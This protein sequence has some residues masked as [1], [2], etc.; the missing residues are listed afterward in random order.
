MMNRAALTTVFTLSF[1]T[2]LAPDL[3]A[4][5]QA[6]PLIAFAVLVFFK[7]YSSGS[8]MSAVESLCAPDSL[9]FVLF[10]SLLLFGT[11]IQSRLDS[12]WEFALV[13]AACLGLARLY[14]AVVPLQEVLEAFFWS[15]VVSIGI[16]VPMSI[17]GFVEAVTT[18]ARFSPFGFHPNLLAFLFGGYFCAMVWKFVTG[19]WRIRILAGTLGVVCLVIIFFASSRGAIAGLVAASA[20]V[21]GVATVRGRRHSG[22]PWRRIAIVATVILAVGYQVHSSQLF[23]T[24]YDFVDQVL[25]LSDPN[26]GV[27]TGLTGR[28]DKW[29]ETMK[30]FSDGTW[31]SGHGLRSSDSMEQLIDNSYLVLLYEVGLIPMML[32][33][34]RFAVVVGRFLIAY[35]RSGDKELRSVHLACSLLVLAFVVNNIVDRHLFSVGNPYSLLGLLFFV[36]PVSPVQARS[37]SYQTSEVFDVQ[38]DS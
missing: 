29:Q 38:I 17:V 35:A 13:L 12:S 2:Y 3:S 26:R 32:I 27:D 31:L 5:V 28:L 19:S 16:F 33:V 22:L 25:A 18:F 23:E 6:I 24:G 21:G 15:A 10:L 8:V 9:A 1:L 37:A 20:V 11:S 4:G 34:A 30:A 14:M 36:S 7:V